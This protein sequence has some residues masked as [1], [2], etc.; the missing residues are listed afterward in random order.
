MYAGG[1]AEPKLKF[2]LG[3]LRQTHLRLDEVEPTFSS[4]SYTKIH[5][6]KFN[7]TLLHKNIH[8]SSN[9]IFNI[10]V[11]AKNE[12]T[13]KILHAKPI[14]CSKLF[15]KTITKVIIKPQSSFLHSRGLG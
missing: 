11:H 13:P 12:F 4:Q 8:M 9:S 1:E 3:S 6:L 10:F 7:H 5:F 2:A 15:Y 14:I